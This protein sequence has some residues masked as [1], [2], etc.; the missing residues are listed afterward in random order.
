MLACTRI[1]AVHSIVFG[2]FS[3]DALA[4]R[5]EESGSTVIITADEGA[6][7][8]AGALKT[9]VDRRSQWT[10]VKV[11]KVIVVECTGADVDMGPRDVWYRRVCWSGDGMQPEK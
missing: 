6:A 2:G 11:N 7:V 3:P 1:G 4:V 10:R 8:V 5:V 9:N